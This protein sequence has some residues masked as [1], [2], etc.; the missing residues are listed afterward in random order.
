MSRQDLKIKNTGKV[1]E[2]LY[3]IIKS[4]VI[5]EK[6]TMDSQYNKITF[7]VS[8]DAS[9]PRIKEAIEKLF[10]VKVVKVNTILE[11]GKLKTFKGRKALRSDTKKAVVTLAEGESVDITTGV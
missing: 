5:T 9:K 4:P 3:S 7:N 11:K 6:S 8:V 2:E 1:T 10:E